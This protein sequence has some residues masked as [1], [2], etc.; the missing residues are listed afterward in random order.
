MLP[1]TTAAF[2]QAENRY[3]AKSALNSLQVMK[4]L[5]YLI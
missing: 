3:N 4:L 1:D 2:G 5:N